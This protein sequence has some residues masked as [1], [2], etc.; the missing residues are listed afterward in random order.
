MFYCKGPLYCT[1]TTYELV[2]CPVLSQ[3][4]IISI[5]SRKVVD[6]SDDDEDVAPAKA[7]TPKAKSK[8]QP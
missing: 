1:E 6:D 5:G 8:A 7:P 4:L 3:V 2:F